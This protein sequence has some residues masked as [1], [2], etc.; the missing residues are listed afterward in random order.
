MFLLFLI[1]IFRMAVK[2]LTERKTRA[3]LTIAGIALGPFALVMISSVI[4]GYGDYIVSQ[5]QGLGQNTIVVFPSGNN[6]L[7]ENDLNNIRSIPGVKR[8]EPFYSIQGQVKVGTETKIVFIYA[9]PPDL[10]FESISG[11]ELEKGSIPSE[12][13]YSKAIIGHKIAY[14]DDG[15]VAYDLGDVLTITYLKSVNGRNEVKRVSVVVNGVVKEFGGA[16]VLSPDLTIILPLEAGQRLLGLSDWSGIYILAENS[17]V[18]QDIVREIQSRYRGVVDVVSF[19]SIA[20]VINS[21]VGAVNFISFAA[22]LSSFAVAVAGVAS[23][24]ITSVIERTRE[25]GVL[26]ALGFRD[27]E[28]LIMILA[29]SIIMSIIGGVIGITLGMIGSHILASTGVTIRAGPQAEIV[30]KAPPKITV[31]GILRATILTLMVGIAGGVFPAYR[32][33]KIPPAVAL[34]YE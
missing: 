22:S 18:V 4:D 32:A 5:V 12:T 21:V 6:K 24:M 8:A 16:F 19:Q 1:D 11:L 30:I 2:V 15:S 14:T 28:V 25:I 33:S 34:R 3:I 23:T 20:N 10:V 26:K 9:I 13:E 31:F 17:N 29:E 7:T 27:R